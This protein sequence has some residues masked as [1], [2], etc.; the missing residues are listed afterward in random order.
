VS[1]RRTELLLRPERIKTQLLQQNGLRR[2]A[3][4]YKSSTRARA[5]STNCSQSVKLTCRTPPIVPECNR[6]SRNLAVW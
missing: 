3:V 2:T 4:R 5:S 6:G 1:K